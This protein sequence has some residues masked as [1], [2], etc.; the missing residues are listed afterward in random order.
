MTN[1]FNE[2]IVIK[3]KVTVFELY[4]KWKSVRL[5]VLTSIYSPSHLE[6]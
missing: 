3:F 6:F 2:T 5:E 4:E 1:I